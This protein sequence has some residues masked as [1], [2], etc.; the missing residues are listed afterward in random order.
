[1]I[2]E[3][4]RNEN[5]YLLPTISMTLDTFLYGYKCIDII[6]LRRTIS[7]QWGHLT[8]NKR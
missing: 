3:V 6:F 5:I 4:F 7:L 2:T 1:M 8:E